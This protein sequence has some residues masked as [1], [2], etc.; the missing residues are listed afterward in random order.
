MTKL[1]SRIPL[2][3]IGDPIEIGPAILFLASSASSYMTGTTVHF[4]GGYTAR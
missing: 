2:R 4:D 3:R 1:L